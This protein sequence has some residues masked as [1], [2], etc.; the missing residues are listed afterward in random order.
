MVTYHTDA[1]IRSSSDDLFDRERFAQYIANAIANQSN[2][3]KYVIG[4]YSPWGYGKTSIL[5]MIEEILKKKDK[6]IIVRYNPWVYSD[7]KSMTAG[8]LSTIGNRIIETESPNSGKFKRLWQRRKLASAISLAND[9]VAL[10]DSISLGPESIKVNSKV[11]SKVTKSLE[12]RSF[13][14]VQR[15]IEEKIRNID[16]K[17]IVVID[18]VD[19]LDKD[20]IFQLFKLVRSVIGFSGVT[21]IIAFDDIVVAKALNG[22]FSNDPDSR[23]GKDFL[24]K[25]IQIPIRLPVITADEFQVILTDK[26]NKLINE[27]CLDISDDDQVR[28]WNTFREYILPSLSTPRA[29]NRYLNVLTFTLSSI[30]NELNIVDVILL[31]GL[32]II[33]PKT[34]NKIHLQ[35]DLLTGTSLEFCLEQYDNIQEQF[36]KLIDP[37]ELDSKPIIMEIFPAIRKIYDTS[38][39]YN[40][41]ILDKNKRVASTDY[42]DRYFIFGIGKSDIADSDIIKILQLDDSA[43]ITKSL[44]DLAT[45]PDKQRLI[46]NKILQY[47]NTISDTE[48]FIEGMIDAVDSLSN[49]PGK[50][51]LGMGGGMDNFSI[52]IIK[53]IKEKDNKIGLIKK[54]LSCC[55]NDGLLST[56]IQ[57]IKEKSINNSDSDTLLTDVE[58][59]EFKKESINKIMSMAKNTKFYESSN[60]RACYLYNLWLEL[61]GKRNDISS[62]LISNIKKP[63]DALKFITGYLPRSRCINSGVSYREDFTDTEY[64]SIKQVIDPKYLYD[65][66]MKSDSSL[67]DIQKYTSFKERSSCSKEPINRL[68]NESSYEF[69]DI[70]AKEF[71]FIHRQFQEEKS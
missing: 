50:G 56:I 37:N 43:K 26:L 24:E 54:I 21:Y 11:P 67:G 52:A 4:L 58:I 34:Y 68:G 55:N 36:E 66:L 3:E 61:G 51:L 10:V 31:T 14:A 20:E 71:V 46:I 42:F 49:S 27:Y 19:R 23:D 63:E 22:R 9:L 40:N 18:D 35:K 29:M 2:S 60:K 8:L 12:S 7:V 28:L 53:L 15:N 62:N 69:K 17:V 33:Y 5:N 48:I 30:K 70:L 39:V 38:L 65:I 16:K 64:K 1:P 6:T 25:I 47:K 44:T 41:D 45:S 13:D 32:Q 59:D 57:Y